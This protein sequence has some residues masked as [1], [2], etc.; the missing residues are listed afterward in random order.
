MALLFSVA[1]IAQ[2]NR[3]GQYMLYKPFIN[4]AEIGNYPELSAALYYRT[5]YAGFKGGLNNQGISANYGYDEKNTFGT[6]LTRDAIGEGFTSRY[7]FF[8]NYSFRLQFNKENTHY[9][10]LGVSAGIETLA[11]DRTNLSAAD[12]GDGIIDNLGYR[13]YTS[14]QASVGATYYMNNWYAGFSVLDLFFQNNTEEDDELNFLKFDQMNFYVYGGY[15]WRINKTWDMDFSSLMRY[16]E[17]STTQFDFNARAT[18]ND[19]LG[20]GMAYR[21]SNEMYIMASVKFL[22]DFT[23]GYAFEYHLENSELSKSGTHEFMLVY[24]LGQDDKTINYESYDEPVIKEVEPA[25]VVVVEEVV[26]PVEVAEV[27]AVVEPIPVDTDGDGV[28]DDIDEC[29]NEVG[30]AENNGCPKIEEA[31][32]EKISVNAKAIQFKTGKTVIAESSKDELNE[33]IAIMKEYPTSKFKI[34]GYSDSVG[35]DKNNQVLSQKR[36]DAVKQFFIDNGIETER[37]TSK[38]YG[39]INPIADNKTAEGRKVNRRVEIHLAE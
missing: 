22:K 33:L 7:R 23:V 12:Q 9:M 37:L 25:E 21:T 4:V 29:P 16:V 1:S 3:I 26:E 14:P 27:V 2:E 35:N 24:Q 13:E 30:L 36:A 34:E 6:T 32:I 18:Y 5:Q 31:V 15:N 17:N 11:I 8:G 20:L 10:L 28:A 38:G 39:E 19:F